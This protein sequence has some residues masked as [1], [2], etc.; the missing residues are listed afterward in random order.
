M[1]ALIDSGRFA[2]PGVLLLAAIAVLTGPSARAAEVVAVTLTDKGMESMRM[3][4]SANKVRAGKVTFNV[5]NSSQ[6]LVHEFI[7]ARS[8]KPVEALPYDE[9]ENELKESAVQ[10]ANEIEDLDPGKSGTLTVDLEPGSYLL[11]CNKAGHFK[12]GMFNHLTVVK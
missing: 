11:L 8:D 4:I 10:V 5:A 9:K 6:T 12:A 7:V 2:A 1:K 3:D